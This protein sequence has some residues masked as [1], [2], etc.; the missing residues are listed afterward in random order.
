[1]QP[2]CSPNNSL[3]PCFW[4]NHFDPFLRRYDP[5]YE[6][7]H[8]WR[9]DLKYPVLGSKQQ[10][11]MGGG[12]IS[13]LDSLHLVINILF[14]LLCHGVKGDS[15]M[16]IRIWRFNM[17]IRIWWWRYSNMAIQIWRFEH[18]SSYSASTKFE[19]P[20]QNLSSPLAL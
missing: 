4:L 9:K 20:F 12:V 1:M 11:M 16:A 17:A 18:G 3:Q 10:D 14:L 13:H 5:S 15:N 2:K 19:S 6:P 8:R 7:N